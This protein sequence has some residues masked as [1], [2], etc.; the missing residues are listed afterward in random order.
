[1]RIL[2]TADTHLGFK[3]GRTSAARKTS[4]HRVFEAFESVLKIAY[5]EKVDAVLHAGDLFNRSKPPRAVIARTYNLLENLLDQDIGF[6]VVPGN[7]ERSRLPPTLLNSFYKTGH[8]L[9]R[10]TRVE[11]GDL[12]VI[13]FPYNG[14]TPKATLS[15]ISQKA[16][17]LGKKPILVLCHQL[18]DGAVYGPHQFRFTNRPEVLE[19]LILPDQVKLIVTGH[20]HRAQALQSNKVVY[21]GSP[22]RT[23]FAEAIEP[24][25]YL[26]IEINSEALSVEFREVTTF[27]MDVLEINIRGSALNYADMAEQLSG[28]SGRAML[29]LTG[30]SLMPEESVELFKRFPSKDWPFLTIAPSSPNRSLRPL[31]NRRQLPFHFRNFTSEV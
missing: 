21:P 22:E 7:H 11:L 8:F 2:A 17:K 30:R 9:Y 19:S 31:Y 28:Y 26:V 10:L 13:G 29:R 5:D 16:R 15:K 1:M 25:G 27:P 6:I 4:Y 18:F 23:S 20:I 12:S 24:K 14:K 3:T